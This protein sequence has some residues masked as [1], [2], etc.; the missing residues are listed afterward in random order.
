MCYSINYKNRI[1]RGSDHVSK[2]PHKSEDKVT[3]ESTTVKRD[4]GTRP[5]PNMYSEQRDVMT[6][7]E[8]SNNQSKVN[9]RILKGT[10]QAL[11]GL[12]RR[13]TI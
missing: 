9:R 12:V 3:T 1:T 11:F 8:K 4:N 10:Q 2:A 7:K 13:P 6:K 5:P